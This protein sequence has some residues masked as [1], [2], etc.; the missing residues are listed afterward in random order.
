MSDGYC[1]KCK[2]IELSKY[3]YSLRESLL[4]LYFDVILDCGVNMIEYDFR[5]FRKIER[6][7]NDK[8]CIFLKYGFD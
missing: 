1:D 7:E 4:W 8:G 6:S 2:N 3:G 5:N